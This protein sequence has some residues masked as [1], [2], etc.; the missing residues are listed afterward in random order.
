VSTSTF[1][2]SWG[3]LSPGG[4]SSVPNKARKMRPRATAKRRCT[5]GLSAPHSADAAER[6]VSDGS[7]GAKARLPNRLARCPAHRLPR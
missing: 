4:S 7:V 3:E 1:E 2:K 6:G 5:E